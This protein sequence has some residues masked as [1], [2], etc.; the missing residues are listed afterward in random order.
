MVSAANI[1]RMLEEAFISEI[2]K[3]PENVQYRKPRMFHASAE[4]TD[5]TQSED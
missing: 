1:T 5:A 2:A 3:K 4:E